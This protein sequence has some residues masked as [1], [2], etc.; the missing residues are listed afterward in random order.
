MVATC[1]SAP[2]RP[3]LPSS[4]STHP[5]P[6]TTQWRSRS[7]PSY[8]TLTHL[9]TPA[10]PQ[11]YS[12]LPHLAHPTSLQMTVINCHPMAWMLP[13]PLV[14]HHHRHQPATRFSQRSTPASAHL[15]L[16]QHR[17]HHLWSSWQL[18]RQRHSP[19]REVG[20]GSSG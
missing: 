7:A 4:A 13:C 1:P 17:L 18:S 15:Q 14:S 2:S 6:P 10:P 16:P 20:K 5:E 11:I 12:P 8:L 19:W 3:P 9:S